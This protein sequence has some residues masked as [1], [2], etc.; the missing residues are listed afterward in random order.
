MHSPMLSGH[1]DCEAQLRMGASRSG[2]SAEECCSGVVQNGGG[3]DALPRPPAGSA[4]SSWGNERKVNGNGGACDKESDAAGF[5]F[6]GFRLNSGVDKQQQQQSDSNIGELC[7]ELQMILCKELTN[8]DVSNIG[9]IVLPKREAEAYLP[10]LSE[11]EGILLDMDDMTLAVTWKFKFR[12]WP[13]NKSRM[14]ILENTAGFV[15]AHCLQAGDFLFIYRNPTS[16][17]HIIRG[18]KGM[19]QRSPL[20]SLQYSSRNQFIVNEDCCSSTL[21][22]KKARSDRR[23][24][25]INP[26]KI[27][28]HGSSSLTMTELNDLEG[29]ITC[30][31]HYF[32]E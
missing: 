5:L 15:R 28:G 1:Q 3:R 2:H 26:N 22:V 25:P 10:P 6:P 20:D 27:I 13:N 16:G 29:D 7:K 11:R 12:F 21:H 19:P 18:N 32:P 23:H 9:R 4:L 24:S 8:S 17:N 31:P 14:Y 30:H